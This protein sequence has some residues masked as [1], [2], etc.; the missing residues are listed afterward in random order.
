[1]KKKFSPKWKASKRPGKQRKFKANAPLHTKSRGMSAHLS[2]EL[3]KKHAKSS[4]Q[5]RKGDSV[6]VMKGQF[7]GKSGKIERTDTKKYAGKC[8]RMGK[9]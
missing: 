9:I 4:I 2:K 6:K 1:M 8:C 5:I 3:R 7:R